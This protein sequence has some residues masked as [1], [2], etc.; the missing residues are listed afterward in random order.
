[1]KIIL[2]FVLFIL[3]GCAAPK[4]QHSE[5]T[6]EKMAGDKFDNYQQEKDG[7]IFGIN[8]KESGP[9]GLKYNKIDSDTGAKVYTVWE[10]PAEGKILTSIQLDEL[11]NI[12]QLDRFWFSFPNIDT[13][14]ILE[15][16]KNFFDKNYAMKLRSLT[17]SGEHNFVSKKEFL[18]ELQATS[19]RCNNTCLRIPQSSKGISEIISSAGYFSAVLDGSSSRFVR[20]SLTTRH[21]KEYK[22]RK[23][24][25]YQ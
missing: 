5:K 12:I 14:A 20:V 25:K 7:I 8:L 2:V 18:D 23:M 3:S 9:Q 17:D 1:M 22:K 13:D 24:E 21:M 6:I 4:Y 16:Q 11:G 10:Y 19:I 15:S